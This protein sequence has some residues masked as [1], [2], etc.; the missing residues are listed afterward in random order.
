MT[1]HNDEPVGTLNDTVAQKNEINT[2]I[3]TTDIQP[4]P[5]RT[6]DR[7]KTIL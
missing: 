4:P 3:T 7:R 1:T 6:F 5:A 2:D